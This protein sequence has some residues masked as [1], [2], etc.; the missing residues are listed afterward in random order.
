MSE[1]I[2]MDHDDTTP[3]GKDSPDELDLEYCLRRVLSSGY[4]VD[5]VQP[6]PDRRS[7]STNADPD[8]HTPIREYRHR[9]RDRSPPVLSPHRL[10]SIHESASSPFVERRQSRVSFRPDFDSTPLG[11]SL[12]RKSDYYSRPEFEGLSQSFPRSA[13]L[14]QHDSYSSPYN[15]PPQRLPKLPQFSGELKKEDV[16]FVVWKYEVNCILKSGMYSEHSI[17][18]SIRRSLRGKARSVL[19]HLGE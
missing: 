10:H 3:R 1:I 8:T 7:L 16:E 19:L 6:R 9:H 12:P 17:L 15:F 2:N 5:T 13:S 14:P 11:S 18:E 4:T